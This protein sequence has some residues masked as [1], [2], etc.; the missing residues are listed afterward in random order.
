MI[1]VRSGFTGTF[2]AS[3]LPPAEL[4]AG[5][6]ALV[7]QGGGFGAYIFSAGQASGIGFS[8]L[9]ATGNELDVTTLE[10]ARE[11]IEQDEVAVVLLYVEAIR[12]ASDL[13]A[14]A[15]RA[16]ELDKPVVIVKVGRTAAGARPRRRTPA[17]SSRRTPSS[18]PSRA[19]SG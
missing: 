12:R 6:V 10:V 14:L 4:Y 5:G 19:S 18:M 2:S 1:G 9:A 13:L 16:D 7:S 8:H 15:R 17:R 3:L 11:L